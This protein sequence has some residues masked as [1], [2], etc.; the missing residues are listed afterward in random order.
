MNQKQLIMSNPQNA[1]M[2]QSQSQQYDAMIFAL[3]QQFMSTPP[4]PMIN[5]N[6]NYQNSHYSQMNRFT[7]PYTVH[8]PNQHRPMN[9]SN[10]NNNINL[11]PPQPQSPTII[12][13]PVIV[14]VPM[15][16]PPQ[17][18]QSQNNNNHNDIGYSANHQG[19]NSESQA[20]NR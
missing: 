11:Q 12:I 3:A 6:V 14:P 1:Q 7:P 20:I 4:V 19:V 10:S 16:I 5:G 9:N 13:R 17:Q 18:Q 8:C 15:L 2:M